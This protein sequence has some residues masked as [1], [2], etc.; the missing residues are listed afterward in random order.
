[1]SL[2]KPDTLI[3]TKNLPKVI[4]ICQDLVYSNSK[5]KIQTP[6]SLAL[7]MS[8]RQISESSGLIWIVNGLGHCVSLCLLPW[9]MTQLSHN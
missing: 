5:G 7:A 1:M 4:S 8:V 3:W 2:K 9:H 6:K